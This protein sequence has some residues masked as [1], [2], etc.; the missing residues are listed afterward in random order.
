MGGSS[1]VGG[2]V[3]LLVHDATD[4]A[5]E[6]LRRRLVVEGTCATAI[7]AD[8]IVR[9]LNGLSDVCK[10]DVLLEPVTHRSDRYGWAGWVHWEASGAHFY[11]WEQPRLFF[12]VDVYACA[13]FDSE[14]V[15]D[16]TRDFFDATDLVAFQF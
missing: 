16:Y 11:A 7:E 3:E 6:I 13:P 10:M 15:A 1:H 4:L 2:M 14:A 5:P 8:A 12:S 9:Y